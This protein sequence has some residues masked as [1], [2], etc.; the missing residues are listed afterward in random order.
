MVKIDLARIHKDK[1][2]I[3]QLLT[4]DSARISAAQQL[5]ITDEELRQTL[6]GFMAKIEYDEY[7]AAVDKSNRCGVCYG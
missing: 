5:G 4:L 7:R 3:R 1:Q 6:R 2:A